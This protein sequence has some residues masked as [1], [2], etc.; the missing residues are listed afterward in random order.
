MEELGEAETL[1]LQLDSIPMFRSKLKLL[2]NISSFDAVSLQRSAES[3]RDACTQLCMSPSVL[4]L[5]SVLLAHANFMNAGR[6]SALTVC[7]SVL[8]RIIVFRYDFY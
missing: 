6:G 8:L 2:H 1:L 3:Y 4:K 5:L 7:L